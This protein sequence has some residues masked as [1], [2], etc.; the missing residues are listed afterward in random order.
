MRSIGLTALGLALLAA[1]GKGSSKS[2]TAMNDELQRDLAA[3]KSSDGIALASSAT[4]YQP[5]RF[6]SDI[7][8]T[9]TAVPIS[10]SPAPRRVPRKQSAPEGTDQKSPDAAPQNE[11]MTGT[12]PAPEPEAEAPA[13]DVPSVPSVS[14]NPRPTPVS[15]ESTAG[16]GRGSGGPPEIGDIIG[17]IIRGGNGG[18]DHCEPPGRRGRGRGGFP[19]PIVQIGGVRIHR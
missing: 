19:F 11:V 12:A 4:G 10:R 9:N 3:A 13:N 8:K 5:M 18:V 6:V 2:S 16:S 7:E 1:C 17:V 15:V 14:V